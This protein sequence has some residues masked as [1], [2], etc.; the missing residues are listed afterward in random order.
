[1]LNVFASFVLRERTFAKLK[2]N[3]KKIALY[4][5]SFL[6]LPLFFDITVLKSSLI[7]YARILFVSK[8][9]KICFENHFNQY[10]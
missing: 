7:Y 6:I 3:L 2:H 8:L 5:Y 10:S 1:M 9:F 4:V